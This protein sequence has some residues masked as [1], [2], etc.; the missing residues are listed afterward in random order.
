MNYFDTANVHFR[1]ETAKFKALCY[2]TALVCVMNKKAIM[3]KILL[4]TALACCMLG[5]KK[6]E[7]PI[8][9][10]IFGKWEL[11]RQYGGFIIPP[12]STYKPGNG[13]I[14]QFNS[15]STYKRYVRG[16]L[17]HEGIYHIRK[18]GQA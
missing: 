9:S 3:K 14:L 16:S 8:S 11:H 13:N 1:T 18:S 2:I 10:S 12:D 5:C 6:S 17:S 4:V 15:D 7:P